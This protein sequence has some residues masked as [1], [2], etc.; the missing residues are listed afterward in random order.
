MRSNRTSIA[1]LLFGALLA[2][3][4]ASSSFAVDDSEQILAIDHLVSHVSTA[5]ATSGQVVQLYV[6]ERVQAGVA[7]TSP[8]FAKRV[9]LFVHGATIPSEVVF[10][11]QYQD[12]SWMAYLAQAGLDV[13]GLDLTGYGPSSRPTAMDDPCNVAP[14]SQSDLVPSTLA[15]VCPSTYAG[16]LTTLASDRD[17]IDAVVD[18]VR[19]LRRVDKIS[20]VVWSKGGSR[21][22]PYVATHPEKVESLVMLAPS[23]MPGN[24]PEA[25]PAPVMGITTR[26]SFDANWDNQIGCAD[27]YDPAI[28]NSLWSQLLLT[29]PTG[30]T[31]GPGA[32]RAPTGGP[33]IGQY[34]GALAGQIQAPTLLLSG[35]YDKQVLPENVRALYADLKTPHKVFADLACT[36][37]LAAWETRHM[38]LFSGVR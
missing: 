18:Y 21:T 28:R 34:W 22:G 37:H 27:Q 19:S 8:S 17:D 2:L 5:P 38:S 1:S 13:F 26:Q 30:A 6:R 23:Y 20:M 33:P 10:D 9:V 12:Y 31:W 4:S 14:A 29:D 11:A 7:L 36:S 24:P 15:D 32:Y 3:A 25:T 16:D 35:E